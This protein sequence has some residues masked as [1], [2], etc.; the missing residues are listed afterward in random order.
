[1]Y[2]KKIENTVPGL[3]DSFFTKVKEHRVSKIPL[4]YGISFFRN[5]KKIDSDSNDVTHPSLQK[6]S[7]W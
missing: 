7:K 1:M 2:E 5:G 4:T 3:V 6:S